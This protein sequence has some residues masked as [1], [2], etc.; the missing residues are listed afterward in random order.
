MPKTIYIH[1][2]VSSQII[3]SEK[4]LTGFAALMKMRRLEAEKKK[5]EPEK[6]EK[7]QVKPVIKEVSLTCLIPIVSYKP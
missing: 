1:Y 7:E 3:M 5:Q 4:K 2:I 6:M